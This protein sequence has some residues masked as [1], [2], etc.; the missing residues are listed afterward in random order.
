[1]L[2]EN[3]TLQPNSPVN[4]FGCKVTY[5]QKLYQID[6]INL[7]IFISFHTIFWRTLKSNL[8]WR[9]F[10]LCQVIKLFFG[11]NQSHS[12]LSK[13]FHY[14]FKLR[15]T[16][17]LFCSLLVR[18]FL[19]LT[20]YFQSHRNRTSKSTWSCSGTCHQLHFKSNSLLN[21]C[22]TSPFLWQILVQKGN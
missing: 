16:L 3:K 6:R 4:Y 19:M 9:Q 7:S 2:K 21:R 13:P 14:N 15:V 20:I 8:N 17:I 5:E 22:S 18:F 10:D 1:M 11:L 12:V